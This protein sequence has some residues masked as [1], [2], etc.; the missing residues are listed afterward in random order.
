M[1]LSELSKIGK[2]KMFLL[3]GA[4]ILLIIVS[5]IDM[6]EKTEEENII[7][8][9]VTTVEHYGEQMET[10]IKELLEKVPG[11]SDVCVIITLKTGREKIVKE[12]SDTSRKQEEKTGDTVMEEAVKKT[13]VLVGE[14]EEPYVVKEN[15][16]QI[17]GI[18]ISGKGLESQ[19]RKKDI[20]DM[21][22]ALFDLPIHKIAIMEK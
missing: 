17:Q 9:R 10:K 12:D 8:D 2:N 15:Y 5:Y 18:A 14:Q 16:P 22:E 3:L 19:K 11:I 6:G 4:G 21:M 20:I 1:K 7:P 13:T